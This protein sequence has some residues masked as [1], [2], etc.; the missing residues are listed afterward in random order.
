VRE[1]DL[2]DMPYYVATPHTT[3]N[4]KPVS[5][6]DG[7]K[8][9]QAFLGSCTNGRLEDLRVAANVVK[10]KKVGENVRFIVTPASQEI[11]RKAI[12]EGVIQTLIDSGALITNPS[13]GACVGGHL[14]LLAGGEVC[15]SST[16]RNFRGRMGSK[17]SEIYLASPLVVASAALAGKII[18]PAK[19]A[20]SL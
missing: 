18:D 12:D 2:S 7:I 11:L 10:G 19:V 17:E 9:D 1:F 8:V 15:I 16:N 14:G 6:I 4:V 13:C 5:E 3:S 20:Q